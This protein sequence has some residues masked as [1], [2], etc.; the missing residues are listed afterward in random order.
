MISILG[1]ERRQRSSDISSPINDVYKRCPRVFPSPPSPA[2]LLIVP[3][4]PAPLRPHSHDPQRQATFGTTSSRGASTVKVLACVSCRW[5]PFVRARGSAWC[6]YNRRSWLH[7][8]RARDR[9][10]WRSLLIAP[11]GAESSPS[12]R[13]VGMTLG[14][15]SSPLIPCSSSLTFSH[16]R[17]HLLPFYSGALSRE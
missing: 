10:T 12:V 6:L 4:A 13:L 8:S 1:N 16:P 3:Q 7:L 17:H 5:W 2:S 15:V 14:H 9:W 11:P